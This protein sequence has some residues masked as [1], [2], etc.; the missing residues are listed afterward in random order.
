MPDS[1][2]VRGVNHDDIGRKR[3]QKEKLCVSD[4]PI[5][6]GPAAHS[7]IY[8]GR[9]IWVFFLF[10][11]RKETCCIIILFTS[12]V[13]SDI[14]CFLFV[15]QIFPVSVLTNHFLLTVFKGGGAAHMNVHREKL[16]AFTYTHTPT[17]RMMTKTNNN[18]KQKIF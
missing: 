17:S 4:D 11:K 1:V 2:Y 10:L 18:N 8:V 13:V 5:C 3:K 9:K 12:V 7:A 15:L 6:G 14:F 16:M